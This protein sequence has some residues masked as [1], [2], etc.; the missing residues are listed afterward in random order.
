MFRRSEKGGNPAYELMTYASYLS[1]PW[2][3]LP[4]SSHFT[5]CMLYIFYQAVLLLPVLFEIINVLMQLKIVV[6]IS[7]K[8]KLLIYRFKC[9]C[10]SCIL[11]IES[12]NFPKR[13]HMWI[14]LV[15]RRDR[16]HR[17]LWMLYLSDNP[18]NTM[19]P[20]STPPM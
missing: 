9:T 5:F 3:W 7:C 14:C 11:F 15:Q 6:L 2:W 10:T 19:A 20:V 4:F 13:H 18:P 17:K 8:K 1:H 16:V 12:F